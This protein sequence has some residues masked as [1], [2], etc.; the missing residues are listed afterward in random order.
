MV[1][2]I[3]N[4]D[5]NYPVVVFVFIFLLCS[6]AMLS[7][8]LLWKSFV[9]ALKCFVDS[10]MSELNKQKDRLWLA[11]EDL[12][13]A[14]DDLKERTWDY[15]DN[16]KQV[17]KLTKELSELEEYVLSQKDWDGEIKRLSYQRD[18][19]Y[20]LIKKLENKH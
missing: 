2:H 15:D 8:Y 6:L 16:R 13:E 18:V 11:V 10:R 1:G 4:L 19:L 7:L 9:F 3:V 5:F 14:T 12:Y 20:N 17:R